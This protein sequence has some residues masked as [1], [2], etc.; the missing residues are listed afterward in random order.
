MGVVPVDL[1]AAGVRVREAV[2][3]DVE[4]LVAEVALFLACL[5]R[6]LVRPVEDVCI[7]IAGSSYQ[8]FLRLISNRCTLA[9]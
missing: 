5:A 2:V 3:V 6:V 8:H 1:G 7:K 9:A 4:R